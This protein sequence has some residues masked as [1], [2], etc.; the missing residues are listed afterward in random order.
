MSCA[1]TTSHDNIIEDP[2][3]KQVFGDCGNIVIE[4]C[5]GEVEIGEVGGSV[6]AKSNAVC[7]LS[8]ATGEDDQLIGDLIKDGGRVGVVDEQQAWV[9]GKGIGFGIEATRAWNR[10]GDDEG[11]IELSARVDD[12]EFQD[13]GGTKQN[14]GINISRD[15]DTRGNINLGRNDHIIP[16]NDR[17]QCDILRLT[18][19]G[20]GFNSEEIS[21]CKNNG[22]RASVQAEGGWLEVGNVGNQQILINDSKWSGSK[23]RRAI[24]RATAC[25]IYQDGVE[26]VWNFSSDVG[27]EHGEVGGVTDENSRSS[28]RRDISTATGDL[29]FSRDLVRTKGEVRVITTARSHVRQIQEL[30]KQTDWIGDIGI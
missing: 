22:G 1:S 21:S 10:I 3:E 20:V 2:R 11:V 4:A 23:S 12:W 28:I 15:V 29:V 24:A 7:N 25:N 6:Y 27:V 8:Q 13:D 19:E 14:G 30:S 5:I 16:S 26:L 9:D 17:L 18:P